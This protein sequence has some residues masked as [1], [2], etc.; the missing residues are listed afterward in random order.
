MTIVHKPLYNLI[1]STLI[2]HIKLFRIMRTFFF[3]ISSYG[4]SGTATDLGDTQTKH[5]FTNLLVLAGRNN[6]T[7]I[8]HCQSNAG[9]NFFK[10]IIFKRI[11]KLIRINIISTLQTG[12][13]D[14][15]RTHAMHRLQMLRMHN[16][17]R[18]LILVSF[19]SKQYAKP[20]I[21]NS[22]FHS[23]IHSFG[24]IIIIMLGSRRMQL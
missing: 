8:R 13:A 20:Y 9:N 18:K 5:T 24:V 6:H 7:G 3:R 23:T 22:A 19:Q 15:V 12:N 11:I 14:G 4:S 10:L 17:S 2:R 16:Q 1:Q 21:V